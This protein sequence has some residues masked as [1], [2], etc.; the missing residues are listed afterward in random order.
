ML[1][2]DHVEAGGVGPVHVAPDRGLRVVLVE[3]VIA[4]AIE[5]GTV[6]VVHPVASGKQ[7]VLRTQ[8]IRGEFSAEGSGGRVRRGRK[9]ASPCRRDCGGAELQKRSS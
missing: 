1:P 7:M 8:R 5:D 4:A 2:V 9:E 6:R 3:H